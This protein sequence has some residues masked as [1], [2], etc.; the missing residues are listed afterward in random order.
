MSLKAA[1]RPTRSSGPTVEQARAFCA[2]A[3]ATSYKR[4]AEELHLAEHISLIRLVNRFGKALERGPLVSA[5]P[6]GEVALTPAGREVL[7]A[8]RRFVESAEALRE[9][10][11]DI[12]FSAYPAIAGRVAQMCAD[13]LD[14]PIPIVLCDVR[15][16]SR[17]DGGAQLVADVVQGELDMVIAPAGLGRE[18]LE[19]HALYDWRLRVVLPA[20]ANPLSG[21]KRV[22]P[23]DLAAFRI[24]AA[25]S[26]HTSRELL[27]TAFA[28][29]GLTLKVS[30]ES[31]NQDLLLAVA[32]DG[33]HYVAVLPDDAFDSDALRSAP[34]LTAR[35]APQLGGSYALYLRPPQPVD[36]SSLENARDVAIAHAALTIRHALGSRRR[37]T[38]A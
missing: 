4:A 31:P 28:V 1:S 5:D 15:E 13:L 17:F 35:G 14:A 9:S 38:S 26:G 19:E 8:A 36:G 23:T 16:A 33:E 7:P 32:R 21:R 37:R 10:P 12:R 20:V 29:R 3:E 2:V 30:L 25:P 6:R 24:A 22:T 27:G 18:G 34:C 11:A